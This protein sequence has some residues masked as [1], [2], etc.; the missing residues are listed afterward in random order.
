M[1][2]LHEQLHDV[3]AALAKLSSSTAAS[4]PSPRSSTSED[5]HV[6]SFAYPPANARAM[7]L[8][9]AT[10]NNESA[11]AADEEVAAVLEDFA[12][13]HSLNR[14][15]A[16][17][18]IVTSSQGYSA[19]SPI[20]ASPLSHSSRLSTSPLAFLFPDGFDYTSRAIATLPDV[21]RTWSLITYFFS[22]AQWYLHVRTR[23]L[24]G[25]VVR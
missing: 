18:R 14:E 20:V 10:A 15:R 3:R 5:D 19:L 9:N 2:S 13:G 6:P 22:T 25:G 16:T 21:E 4:T 17:N 12:M 24:H 1:A 7:S 23:S 8:P 11:T